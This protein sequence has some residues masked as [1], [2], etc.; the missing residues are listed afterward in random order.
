LSAIFGPELLISPGSWPESEGLYSPK[1]TLS[2]LGREAIFGQEQ[3]LGYNKK[4]RAVA[5][6]LVLARRLIFGVCSCLTGV[7]KYRP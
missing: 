5:G 7:S 4:T 3:T 2:K 1:E 6:L